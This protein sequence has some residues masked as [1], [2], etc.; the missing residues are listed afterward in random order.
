MG[1]SCEYCNPIRDVKYNNGRATNIKRS[2]MNTFLTALLIIAVVSTPSEAHEIFT[3]F[4][5]HDFDMGNVG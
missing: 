3:I 2:I 5:S 4:N 1:K